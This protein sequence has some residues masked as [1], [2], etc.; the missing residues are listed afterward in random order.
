MFA[1]LGDKELC[2]LTSDSQS[3]GDG[4]VGVFQGGNCRSRSVGFGAIYD[5]LLLRHDIPV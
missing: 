4:C 2:P 3:V 1:Q 5:D